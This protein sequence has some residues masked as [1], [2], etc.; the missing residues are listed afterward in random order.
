M[1]FSARARP[2]FFDF[3]HGEKAILNLFIQLASWKDMITAN[4]A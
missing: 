4:D 2:T 3:K 1:H